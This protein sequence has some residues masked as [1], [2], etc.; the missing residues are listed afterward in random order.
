[1]QQARAPLLEDNETL[2]YHHSW[3]AYLDG[4]PND[5]MPAV[6]GLSGPASGGVVQPNG[7]WYQALSRAPQEGKCED[8]LGR[9][10]GGRGTQ[11]GG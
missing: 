10:R 7:Q 4:R 8:E 9:T 1:M 3:S 11:C 2:S 5:W 6:E